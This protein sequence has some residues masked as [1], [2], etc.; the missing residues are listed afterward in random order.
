[1]CL[2]LA[3]L[4]GRKIR[5][6]FGEQVLVD[7]QEIAQCRQLHNAYADIK[8]IVN[9]VALY[10]FVSMMLHSLDVTYLQRRLRECVRQWGRCVDRLRCT[11]GLV[12]QEAMHGVCVCVC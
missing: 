2:N 10:R 12:F 11:D 6:S 7:G 5:H 4:V 3:Q 1:M 8:Y 9:H